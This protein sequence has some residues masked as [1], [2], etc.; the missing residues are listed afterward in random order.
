MLVARSQLSLSLSSALPPALRAQWSWRSL[1][2]GAFV[3]VLAVLSLTPYLSSSTELVRLRNAL[4]LDSSNSQNFDWTPSSMP[5]DFMQERAAP[6][7]VFTQ[8]VMQLGLHSLDSDH[9]KVAAISRHLLSNPRLVGTPIQMD[10]R[11]TYWHIWDDGTG[12]CGDFTRVFMAFALTAGIPVRA[13]SFSFDGFGGHGHVLPEIWNR[14]LKA[15]QLVDIFNNYYFVKDH[16]A[17]L[18][19]LEFRRAMDLTPDALQL[20]PL[21]P[22]ARPGFA[23]EAKAW[24]YYRRGLSQWY[25]AWGNNVFTYDRSFLVRSLAHL[26]RA[27]E[28]VGGIAQGVYPAIHILDDP[29]NREQVANLR[30]VR[31]HLMGVFALCLA[32]SIVMVWGVSV[33]W[34]QWLQQGRARGQFKVGA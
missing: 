20:V 1:W 30:W 32:A 33:Q 19:A 15:W 26:S 28:Q 27:L 9:D 8:A 5:G 12:Y 16:G 34:L 29:A 4:L 6:D 3:W 24:D 22:G 25:L 10:L 31:L 13:W 18:S 2:L 23:I 7:A 21:V 14:Q 17:P 11:S